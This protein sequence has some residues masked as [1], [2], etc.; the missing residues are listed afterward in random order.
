MTDSDE[1]KKPYYYSYKTHLYIQV[2][3]HPR[4]CTFKVLY[5]QALYIQDLLGHFCTFKVLYI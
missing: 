1:T 3:V 5:I 4:C 2:F